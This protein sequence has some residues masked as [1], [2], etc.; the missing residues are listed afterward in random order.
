MLQSERHQRGTIIQ[1]LSVYDIPQFIVPKFNTATQK[2]IGDKVRQAERLRAWAKS[3]ESEFTKALKITV[4]E[5]FED[6]R[7][8]RKHMIA[9]SNEIT[10]TLNP[11][12]FDEERVRVQRYLKSL[13]GTLVKDVAVIYGQNA[14]KISSNTTYIGL[15]AIASNSCQLT[16]STVGEAEVSGACRYLPEGTVIAKLRPY[17][18]K[19]SYI[20]SHLAGAVGSTELLCVK[21]T[22]N[23][24]GWYLYG[25]LK[26]EL[27]LKQIRPV[28][29]GATHPR[30]DQDD[31]YHLVIPILDN[32]QELGEHLKLAQSSYFIS[33]NLTTSA[34]LLVEGLIEGLVTEAE[35][36]AAQQGLEAGDTEADAA[37]LRRLKTDGLD[38]KGQPL[39]GDVERV[40]ELLGQAKT[41]EV[42]A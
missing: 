20:P 21:P 25:V 35:L 29:T 31:I 26:S 36:I 37:I 6:K 11:G 7:T 10:Y 30:I 33:K 1:G 34:K 15:D 16:P 22:G 38:G 42:G 2:Y 39:F 9:P 41:E 40:Y 13:D 3:L 27:V 19:V 23:L 12:A 4:S 28:A 8:D 5:A 18:N 24:S 17:L 14:T 32:H